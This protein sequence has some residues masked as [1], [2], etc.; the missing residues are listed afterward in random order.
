MFYSGKPGYH[1]AVD[2][3]WD[4]PRSLTRWRSYNYPHVTIVYWSLYRLARN[5]DGAA[6][7]LARPWQWYLRQAVNTTL[8]VQRHGG[9]NQF[10]TSTLALDSGHLPVRSALRFTIHTLSGAPF[11]RIIFIVDA[12]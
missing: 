1:Y 9:Y 2:P 12:D 6:L 7:G 3:C 4:R 10:G 8:G 5:Y 11:L